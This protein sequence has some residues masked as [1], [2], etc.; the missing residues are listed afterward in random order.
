MNFY[1][2]ALNNWK[3]KWA[4]T[5]DAAH[6]FPISD[7]YQSIP[8]GDIDGVQSV[9]KFG[10]STNVDADVATDVWDRA[11]ATDDQA[12]WLGPLSGYV[13]HE[14]VST[15]LVDT[16]LSTTG[17]NSIQIYG[18]SEWDQKEVSEVVVLQ[19]QT[20]VTTVNS[21]S[22]IHRMKAVSTGIDATSAND[23]TITATAND[24]AA[25]VTA[26]INPGEG[27][28]Q[29]AVYGI[30]SIQT[31]YMTKFYATVLRANLGTTEAHADINLLYNPNFYLEQGGMWLVKHSTAAGS[32]AASLQHDYKPYN[33]FEGPGVIKIQ[34]TGSA[35]NLDVSAGFDLILVDN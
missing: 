7:F 34:A 5:R 14:I 8:A 33:K 24:I 20:P 35:N 26:Q 3:A 25:R 4:F 18:I 28:T 22:L 12:I 27:Q 32:R 16:E 17:C 23:G 13:T 6:T 9:N 21:Y 1:S 11:N 2:T 19:G 15:S 29:M 30:P 31:A 10:R